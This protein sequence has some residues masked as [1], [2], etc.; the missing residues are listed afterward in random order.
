MGQASREGEQAFTCRTSSWPLAQVPDRKRFGNPRQVGVSGWDAT[1]RIPTHCGLED[2]AVRY[3]PGW[4]LGQQ[5]AKNSTCGPQYE[6][7]ERV[8]PWGRFSGLQ[9]REV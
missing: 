1:G 3:F 8:K 7:V 4:T 5:E 2:E 9:P 6:T